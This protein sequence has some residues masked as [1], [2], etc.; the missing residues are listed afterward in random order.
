MPKESCIVKLGF[1]NGVLSVHYRA[2][3]PAWIQNEWE[4]T[5][6]TLDSWKYR[7]P[8]KFQNS[9]EIVVNTSSREIQISAGGKSTEFQALSLR[10]A[11]LALEVRELFCSPHSF[12]EICTQLK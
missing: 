11:H 4:F 1:V 3:Y 10:A 9:L 2:S 7:W 6:K 8:K 5:A 12:R